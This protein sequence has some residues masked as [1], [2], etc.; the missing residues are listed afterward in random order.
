MTSMKAEARLRLATP[1]HYLHALCEHL[2][3]RADAVEL[4]PDGGRVSF[5]FGV[6]TITVWAKGLDLR[7]EG[8][9]LTSLAYVKGGLAAQLQSFAPAERPEIVWTG[10]GCADETPPNFRELQVVDATDVT[11]RTRRVTLTGSDLGR[12]KH[13]GLHVRLLIPPGAVDP[14]WPR[15]G[16]NG[17]L[18]FP[19][20]ERSLALRTYTIRRL[21]AAAGRIEIDFV[22]HEGACPGSDWARRAMRGNRIGMLGPGGGEAG[23]ADWYLLVGDE[24][25]LPAI[26]RILEELPATARGVVL[27]EVA[28]AG[29]ELPL[30][31]PDK[32]ELRWLHRHGAPAGTSRLLAEAACSVE[33]PRDGRVFV[34][35]GTEFATFRLLRTHWRDTCG[36]GKREH[37]AMAYWRRGRSEDEHWARAEE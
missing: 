25:G 31:R 1:E 34:W 16:R 14:Q 2:R 27:V 19:E 33:I 21:D 29:E 22:L 5:P 11:P 17:L 24:T 13:G 32:V 8:P 37:L 15:L 28:D 20:G 10:D 12:F 23:R 4:S 35:A 26:G 3:E 7:A 6:A 18:V 30:A 9:D 36:L